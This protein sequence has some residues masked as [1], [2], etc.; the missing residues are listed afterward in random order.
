MRRI[1]CGAPRSPTLVASGTR[2]IEGN[3]LSLRGLYLD[4]CA[5]TPE[6]GEYRPLAELGCDGS[7]TAA[8]LGWLVRK[9]RLDAVNR[10]GAGIACRRRS[11]AT[12]R[13]SNRASPGV[14]VR[15]GIA[16]PADQALPAFCVI[17]L[18]DR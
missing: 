6:E 5:A 10:G 17:S 4:A 14:A 8:P 2:R 3:T 12:A 1:S 18:P 9:G 16:K 13:T 11:R 7:Y 15:R